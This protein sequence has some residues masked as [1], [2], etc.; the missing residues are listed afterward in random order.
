MRTELEI[1]LML[2]AQSA[3]LGE[4][5]P[6]FRAVSFEIS[7]DGEDFAAR[8]IFD[9]KPSDDAREVVSVVLTNLL[10]N[11]SKIHRSYKEEILAVPYPEEMQHLSLLV[12]LRNEDD[13]NSWS[14]LYKNT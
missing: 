7:P 3:L 11:Y 9:G 14:K 8:F 1:K 2:H 5:A 10:S 6:S 13:W 12:Y 4:V